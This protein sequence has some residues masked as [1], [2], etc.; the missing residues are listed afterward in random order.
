MRHSITSL[1][2]ATLIATAGAAVLMTLML[3]AGCSTFTTPLRD[4]KSLCGAGKTALYQST[5]E[6]ERCECRAIEGVGL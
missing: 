1:A 5:D 2:L 4:C 3:A 6:G